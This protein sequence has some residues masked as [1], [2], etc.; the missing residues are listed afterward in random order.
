MDAYIFDL[1]KLFLMLN[2][3]SSQLPEEGLIGIGETGGI[4]KL[5][6]DVRAKGEF[7][8]FIV[9]ENCVCITS[10]MSSTSSSNSIDL[11]LS[12][13]FSSYNLMFSFLI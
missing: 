1:L 2:P 10:S 8:V 6:P 4:R 12:I 13:K 9:G 5:S 7:W 3:L 11:A